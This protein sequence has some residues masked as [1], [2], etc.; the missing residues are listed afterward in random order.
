MES[1]RTAHTRRAFGKSVVCKRAGISQRTAHMLMEI[2]KHPALANQQRISDL[3]ASWATLYELQR[4][5]APW[6]EAAINAGSHRYGEKYKE[7]VERFGFDY[8][9]SANAAYV[10]K[11]VEVSRRREGLSFGHYQEVVPLSPEEQEYWLSVAAPDTSIGAC[12]S[13]CALLSRDAAVL[14]DQPLSHENGAHGTREARESGSRTLR[15]RC[16]SS[17]SSE[18]R[19]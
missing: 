17:P 19:R 11:V 18:I 3:P 4:P 12:C 1:V 15:A 14:P 13:L 8:G 9:R 5:E 6:L 7:A 16:K 2:A 10:C